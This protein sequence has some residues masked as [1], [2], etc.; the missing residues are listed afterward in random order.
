MLEKVLNLWPVLRT[1]Y[2]KNEK[3]KIFPLKDSEE[4]I[5][6]LFA[7]V[8]PIS[9]IMKE[10]QAPQAWVPGKTL[11]TMAELKVNVLN[12]DADI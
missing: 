3:D 6:Q 5:P 12:S 8:Y 1:H 4:I 9:D 10:S 11:V 2:R 7:L